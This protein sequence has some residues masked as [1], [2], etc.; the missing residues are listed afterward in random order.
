MFNLSF[1][2]EIRRGKKVGQQQNM[3]SQVRKLLEQKDQ[4]LIVM[5]RN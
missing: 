3:A 2:K 4:G 5:V 1:K